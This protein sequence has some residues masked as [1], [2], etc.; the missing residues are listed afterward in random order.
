GGSGAVRFAVDRQRTAGAD[1]LLN[2]AGI[3][4]RQPYGRVTSAR[5]NSH[6]QGSVLPQGF[7]V[8]EDQHVAATPCAGLGQCRRWPC[9]RK[10]P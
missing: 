1:A 4:E 9:E 10:R 8:S 7:R 6:L 5:E 2:A 3:V